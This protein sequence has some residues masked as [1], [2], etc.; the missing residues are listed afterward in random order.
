VA[1]ES[2]ARLTQK[3]RNRPEQLWAGSAAEG[4]YA[5]GFL[6][7]TNPS[8]YEFDHENRPTE[9]Q[10][11]AAL[12]LAAADVLFFNWTWWDKEGPVRLVPFVICNDV[13]A[14]AADCEDIEWDEV[15]DLLKAYKQESKCLCEAEF[16]MIVWVADRRGIEHKTWRGEPFEDRHARMCKFHPENLNA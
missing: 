8:K 7:P 16:K 1:G 4:G 5:V 3:T 9:A 14:P 10:M 2:A 12:Q 13:F 15:E 6:I 11:W